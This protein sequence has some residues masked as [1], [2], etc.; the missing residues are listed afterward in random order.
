MNA[1]FVI[2]NKKEIKNAR[3]NWWSTDKTTS[4]PKTH[5]I[6]MYKNKR[7]INTSFPLN[8]MDTTKCS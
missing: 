6:E 4:S 1:T 3:K 8:L 5:E 2:N 7:Q